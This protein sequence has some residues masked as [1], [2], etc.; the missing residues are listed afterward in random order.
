MAA[1]DLYTDNRFS[2]ESTPVGSDSSG[3]S[4]WST[5]AFFPGAHRFVITGGQFISNAIEQPAPAPSDFRRIPLGDLDLRNEI[6]LDGSGVVH[7][8]TV[9]V[10]ARLV[11][12]A[13]IEVFRGANA[14]K[15]WKREIAKYSGIRH[16]NFVQLY[17]TV[18][19]GGLYA[20]IFHDELVPLRE[21]VEEYQNSVISTV[22]L[23]AL[24]KKELGGAIQYLNPVFGEDVAWQA[25]CGNSGFSSSLVAP[26]LGYGAQLVG[27]ASSLR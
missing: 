11:Y 6:R 14:E 24:F 8:Q 15:N 10:C 20:M 21:Y 4:S 22:Y 17:G 7:L 1:D 25:H 13:R 5:G 2:S 12:T 26:E 19:S 16:P 27:S 9:R 23:Y 3:A 18:D